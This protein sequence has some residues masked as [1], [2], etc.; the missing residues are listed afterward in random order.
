MR[1]EVPPGT[2]TKGAGL[3]HGV[4]RLDL[5]MLMTMLPSVLISLLLMKKWRLREDENPGQVRAVFVRGR[6]G[7]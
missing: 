3:P 2:W 4:I 5:L 7:V 6:D 1:T